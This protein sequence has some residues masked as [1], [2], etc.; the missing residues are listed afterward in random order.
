[1]RLI[2]CFPLV[3]LAAPLLVAVACY[4]PTEVT[5]VVST[6]LACSDGPRTAIF[7]GVPFDVAPDAETDECAP[8][9]SGDSVVGSLV[10]VPS[11]DANGRA[12]VKVVLARG[13]SPSECDANPQECIVATRSFSFVEHLSRR[14]P[15]RM[16]SACLGKRCPDGQTCGAGGA[17]VSNEVTCT[18]ADCELVDETPDPDG[19]PPVTVEDAGASADADADA[20]GPT[21]V[22]PNG[23][24][25]IAETGSMPGPQ[26]AAFS[27][28]AFYY[29]EAHRV[30]QV[31]KSGGAPF[32]VLDVSGPLGSG[33]VALST[34][35]S[36]WALVR[37]VGA[38]PTTSYRF[39]SGLGKGEFNLGENNTVTSLAAVTTLGQHVAYVA[40]E[41]G[42][43]KVTI[44]PSGVVTSFTKQG[45]QRIAADDAA[46]FASTDV[47]VRVLDRATAV[48][49]V[50]TLDIHPAGGLPVA[51]ATDGT[52]VH[53]SGAVKASPDAAAIVSLDGKT[54]TMTTIVPSVDPVRSLAVDAT[55]V[56]W[57]S[58]LRVLRASRSGKDK[59]PQVL[60][61]AA[62]GEKVDH[63]AVDAE[64]V[65]F[66]H[67]TNG[68]VA[69]SLLEVRPKLPIA[70]RP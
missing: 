59:V 25:F 15:I 58:D 31:S 44:G 12:G 18:S 43:D 49:V 40:R 46:V 7:K 36:T 56:Y 14:L 55:H 45:A 37:G 39:A 4:G 60:F 62:P 48:E 50:P 11:S 38:G 65:Y 22:G 17:C 26:A 54:G 21:C 23:A 67:E 69:Q 24:G 41:T 20:A 9:A 13:R 2:R 47:G 66:W 3:A 28:D 6:D 42:I 51:F 64:C 63:L 30:M 70:S 1:M 33:L 34:V 35:S 19:G 68:V 27:G 57:T 29:L 5:V 61:T 10:F 53:A 52:T 16:L 8:A 32:E